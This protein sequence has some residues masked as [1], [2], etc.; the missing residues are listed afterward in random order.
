VTVTVVTLGLLATGGWM[1]ARSSLFALER[2]EV[3]GAKTLSHTDI[4]RA[5]GLKAGAN[6]LS[7]DLEAV[8]ERVARLP[9]VRT[10]EVTKPAPSRVRILVSER[11]PAFVL[12]TIHGL[13]Y[14][15][16][17]A[18]VLK[19]A[20]ALDPSLPTVRSLSRAPDEV[21]DRIRTADVSNAM[22][23]WAALPTVLRGRPGLIDVTAGSFTLWRGDLT[24]KFGRF[25][26]IDQKIEAVRLVVER[27]KA[28]RERLTTIDVRS[29][30]RPAAI[31]AQK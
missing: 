18:V 13:Y 14:L 26:R 28:A 31:A 6:M 16:A 12:E 5:S 7:L 3:A 17:E 10:V 25:D 15:D 29:P 27:A 4:V 23:L 1:L 19:A 9:L 22:S 8:E 24:I 20:S 30:S 2:I 21:G 11:S